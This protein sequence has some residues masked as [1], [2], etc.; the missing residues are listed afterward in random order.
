MPVS[1]LNRVVQQLRRIVRT[2]AAVAESDAALLGRFIGD[3]D[4][5]AFA[6]LVERHG[7]LVLGVCRR[8]LGD[9]R[10]AEDAFQATFVVLARQAGSIGQREILASWLYRV[11]YRVAS[12]ARSA[13]KT[14]D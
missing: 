14:A 11:A 9:P 5:T 13:R 8:L 2:G 6:A 3:R 12:S 1:G 4:E 7:P 10:K